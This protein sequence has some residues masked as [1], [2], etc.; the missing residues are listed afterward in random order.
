MSEQA[1]AKVAVW[2]SDVAR[3]PSEPPFHPDTAYPEY[4]FER[5]T[6]PN[7]VYAAV[8]ECFHTA[9][10]DAHNFGS[11]AW[12]P[13]R[14]LIHPG[15]TVLLKPNLVKEFHPR[16]PNGWQYVLTHGS[17]IRAAADY[18]WKALEGKGRI[19]IADAPH[20]DS[21]FDRIVSVLA[22]DKIAG[23]YRTRGLEMEL[24][25]LRQEEWV[26]KHSVIVRRTRRPGDPRGYIPFDL[27]NSSE[28]VGHSG[29]GRYI[30]ADYDLSE[31]NSH[32]SGGRHEYLIAASA[33][34]CDVV[35][36]LP[37]LKTHKKAGITASLKNL[38]GING[39]KNW[40]PHY[41]EGN[42]QNGGDEHPQPDLKHRSERFLVPL[43]Y[44][45][46]RSLP[47]I[48]PWLHRAGRRAGM[49][50]F[51]KTEE[52]VRS[53]NW[54]GNDTIWRMCLDLNK[55]IA[56]GNTD[57]TLRPGIPK[58]RKRH[59]VLVDGIVAG[60]GRG[61][62]DPDPVPV[63]IVAFGLNAPSVDAACACLMGYDPDRIPIV[64]QAFC[65]K[66]YPLA[67][68]NWAD[69]HMISNNRCWCGPLRSLPADI[70]FH[71]QPHFGWAGHIEE[72]KR[73]RKDE[74]PLKGLERIS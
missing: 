11:P 70:M 6:E 2:K 71:F 36:S 25:D 72:F 51:G 65:C 64:R 45:L 67:E 48:G 18:V 33:I 57:G 38:V 68:W 20:T 13:L 24:I 46:S 10:L 60:E 41:T 73:S 62:M 52:V 1:L 55:I 34:K 16:D 22:L 31:L 42:P 28:F 54:W 5:G 23:F 47:V 19:I 56:Y 3:Y 61:P 27:A 66:E 30:G 40:L 7:G 74:I 58:S 9:A 63:G 12:N 32:H 59:Y 37:K 44:R 15:E 35:F 53:G 50:V 8:R 4:P 29:A 39:D 17:I 49:H 43:A 14:E 69:V 26:T 21:S